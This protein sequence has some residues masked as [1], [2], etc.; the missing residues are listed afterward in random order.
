MI[1]I[2]FFMAQVTVALPWFFSTGTLMKTS[3]SRISS[4]SL[5][6]CNERPFTRTAWK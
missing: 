2:R 6:S 3:A 4:C 1:P 5:A